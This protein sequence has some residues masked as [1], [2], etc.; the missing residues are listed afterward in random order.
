MFDYEV[1]VQLWWNISS[2][3]KYYPLSSTGASKNSGEVQKKKSIKS[4]NKNVQS[5]LYMLDSPLKFEMVWIDIWS[6]SRKMTK[7]P[8]RS[9]DSLNIR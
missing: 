5:T 9:K 2:G 7:T 6:Y 3:D 8:D 1:M 4:K